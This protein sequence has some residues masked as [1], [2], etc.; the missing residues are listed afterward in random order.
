M[1]FAESSL[2]HLVF[3]VDLQDIPTAFWCSFG[4]DQFQGQCYTLEGPLQMVLVKSATYYAAKQTFCHFTKEWV[5]FVEENHLKLS[6]T[7]ILTKPGVTEFEVRRL[8]SRF[9]RPFQQFLQSRGCW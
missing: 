5:D 7:L 8:S 1:P 6:D 2:F 4:E 9:E 3:S